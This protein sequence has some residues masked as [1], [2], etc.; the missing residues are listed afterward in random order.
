MLVTR[1]ATIQ[2]RV[3]P[4]VKVASEQVLWRIG[5]NMSEAVELFLRRV[6]TDERIPFDVVAL[7]TGRTETHV[8]DKHY[9]SEE[10]EKDA[11]AGRVGE[12]IQKGYRPKKVFKKFSGGRTSR[13]IRGGKMSKK[14]TN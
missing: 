13:R 9:V 10:V 7:E 5:L 3:A 11:R 4:M 12:S 2:V 8:V 14:G 6:I 1:S